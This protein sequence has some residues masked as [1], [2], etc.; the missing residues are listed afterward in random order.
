MG[1]GGVGGAALPGP[2]GPR[3]RPRLAGTC[4]QWR[5]DVLVPVTTDHRG[6]PRLQRQHQGRLLG[7]LL[8]PVTDVLGPPSTPEPASNFRGQ[9][10]TLRRPP[11]CSLAREGGAVAHYR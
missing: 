8:Q 11:R 9:E 3:A 7:L 1:T 10:P 6:A 4:L 5:R 2:L